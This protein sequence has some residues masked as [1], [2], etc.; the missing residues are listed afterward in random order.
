MGFERC[1]KEY[2]RS[3]EIDKEKIIETVP[4]MEQRD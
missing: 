4:D 1:R 2:L 3:V